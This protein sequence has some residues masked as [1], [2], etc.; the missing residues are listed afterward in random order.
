MNLNGIRRKEPILAIIYDGGE[1][2]LSRRLSEFLVV[3]KR[4]AEWDI[5]FS[6]LALLALVAVFCVVSSLAFSLVIS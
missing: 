5:I 3:D 1:F 2:A 4:N 6:A